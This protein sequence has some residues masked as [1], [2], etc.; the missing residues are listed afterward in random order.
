[1]LAAL[2]LHLPYVLAALSLHLQPE[3]M[4]HWRRG[5]QGGRF[6][7][8]ADEADFTQ[9]R[10]PPLLLAFVSWPSNMHFSC[11]HSIAGNFIGDEG[12]KAVAAVLPQTELT[13]LEYA[14]AHT[15][16]AL[17]SWPSNMHFFCSRPSCCL[18][19]SRS[20]SSRRRGRSGAR[21]RPEREHHPHL[22]QVR[23]AAPL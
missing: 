18:W 5:R 23:S 16:L 1:M 8:A 2:F 14:E 13:S 7:A 15:V 20:E 12:G 22:T 3:R 17:M 19:Q 21:S 10:F 4:Q 6:C 9:V 11:T